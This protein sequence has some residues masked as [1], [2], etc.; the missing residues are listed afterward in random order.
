M[1]RFNP[2]ILERRLSQSPPKRPPVSRNSPLRQPP[3][4]LS[5]PPSEQSA[6]FTRK[7]SPV[8]PSPDNATN[9]ATGSQEDERE[10]VDPPPR[11]KGAKTGL[12]AAPRRSLPRPN[13]RPLPPPAPE[14]DADL[15]PFLG[16]TLRRSPQTG[17]AMPP[18]PE[19][20]LP[21][22]VPDAVSSTP[23]RGIHSSS[24]SKWRGRNK[25]PSSSPLK[26][27]PTRPGEN[28]TEN[29]SFFNKNLKKAGVRRGPLGQGAALRE[30]STNIRGIKPRDANSE[31]KRKRDELAKE[32]QALKRDLDF[33][34]RE[35]DRIRVMLRS[36]RKVTASDEDAVLDLLKRHLAPDANES[37][38]SQ[39]ELLAKAALDPLA[40]VPMGRPVV[41]VI[42]DSE[43]D[44]EAS[45]AVHS[46]R[47]V[48]MTA[49]EE[50]PFL[51]LFSPFSVSSEF[52]TL[53]R[54]ADEPLRQQFSVRLQ[55]RQSPALFSALV[56]ITLD[57]VKLEIASI[58]VSG[59]EPA[60]KPELESF[61]QKICQGEC[62][63][64][65]ER[66]IGIITWAMAE[67][68][69]ISERR[70]Q[71]WSKLQQET[72]SKAA[73]LEVSR[74]VRT[75]VSRQRSTKGSEVDKLSYA[76]ADLL[77][78]MGLQS[79]DIKIPSAG[80]TA[81]IRLNWRVE[82]DWTGEAQ[83]KVSAIVSIPGSWHGVDRKGAF[84]KLPSLFQG[85]VEGGEEPNVAVRK[86]VALLAGN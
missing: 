58:D 46:H 24:P 18:P 5:L 70:A 47:P 28:D 43:D 86:V 15:N 73:I 74:D 68:L 66:N 80:S 22:S 62:N 9:T 30:R 49:A 57:A 31:K 65:M 60:A 69:R 83:S 82:F 37:L 33:A 64:S 40:L 61:L 56:K 67:W 41:A 23:P 35:N 3:Q 71:F 36:G 25:P 13:P 32:L 85:L 77:P 10:S 27:P 76:I 81:S 17:T 1:S 6:T 44:E 75:K 20:E 21:P 34:E 72:Q 4:R 8:R 79:F 51:E 12:A 14:G 42:P 63:R 16:N 2:E 59:L 50:L 26:R 54:I 29:I 38:P 78:F 19:P 39:S 45:D 7:Q 48:V 55:A 11:T 53:P 84:G 52:T